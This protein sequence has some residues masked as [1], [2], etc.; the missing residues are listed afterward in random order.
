MKVKGMT[1][2]EHHKWQ[3]YWLKC[4]RDAVDKRDWLLASDYFRSA[5]FHSHVL[6]ALKA[7]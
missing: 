4:A 3:R 5:A 7:K 6:E 1:I 2:K